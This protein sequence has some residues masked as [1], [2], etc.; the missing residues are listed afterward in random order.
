M[1]LT[2]KAS[3]KTLSLQVF[4]EAKGQHLLEMDK[5]KEDFLKEIED[6]FQIINLFQSDKYRLVGLPFYNESLTKQQFTDEFRSV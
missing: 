2:E 3:K 5:W 4:I 6:H 1:F